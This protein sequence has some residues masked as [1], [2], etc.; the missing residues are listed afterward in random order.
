MDGQ[1]SCGQ[2]RRTGDRGEDL[3][4]DGPK[5]FKKNEFKPHLSEYWKI[6]PHHDAEFVTCMEDVL[7]VYQ[8]PYDS[9]YPVVCMDESPKQLIGDEY[10]R[11]GVAELFLAVEP[12]TGKMIAEVE[13][14]RAKKDWAPGPT[15]N[16]NK[17]IE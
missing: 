13:N 10:V 17:K 12:L 15:R 6:P 4:D 5:G 8:R 14:K 7:D 16:I 3:A 11:L 2:T 9:S 1:A